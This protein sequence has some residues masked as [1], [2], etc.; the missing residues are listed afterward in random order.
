MSGCGPSSWSPTD[1]DG[2]SG[3]AFRGQGAGAVGTWLR[4]WLCHPKLC[5]SGDSP[6]SAELQCPPSLSSGNPPARSPAGWGKVAENQ[7]EYFLHT[8]GGPASS[9]STTSINVAFW[10]QPP[11]GGTPADGKWVRGV[12]GVDAGQGAG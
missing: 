3:S 7:G 10:V 11:K 12:G 4:S 6:D 5:A 1:R 8:M 9:S 2:L